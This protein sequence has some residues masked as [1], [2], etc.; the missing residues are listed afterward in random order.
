MINSEKIFSKTNLLL[1]VSVIIVFVLL[2]ISI[3][4]GK[5]YLSVKD[6]WKI[7]SKSH[8]NP[9]AVNV[10]Y[11]LRLPRSIMTVLAGLGLGMAGSVFQTVFKNPL[12]SPDIIGVT[13][14]ANVGAAFS[15][16]FLSGNVFTVAFGAFVGGIVAIAFVIGLVTLSNTKDIQ[17]YVLSGI[18]MNAIS[19]GMIM[20]LKYFSDPENQLGAIEFWTMGSFGSITFEKLIMILPFFLVGAIGIFFMRWTIYMLSLNDEEG[21]A[22]GISVEQSRYFVL[23]FSTLIVASIV[24]VTGLISFM[25]LIPPHIARAILKRNNFKTILF[26]GLLGAILMMVS[27]CI[28][29]S[30]LH[31]ELPV[32]IITSFIGAPYLAFLVS[33]RN[34]IGTR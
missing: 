16:V 30:L 20:I 7:I 9:M 17:T 29:R 6:I 8:E 12:A 33:R 2:F 4:I 13:S 18:V 3:G 5:Y 21:K 11:K 24:S 14:G 26:S 27:D 31:S 22:L 15:I 25:A 28:A 23:L 32:S 34:L 10:F 19:N 1:V